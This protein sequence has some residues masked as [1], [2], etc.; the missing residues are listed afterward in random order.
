MIATASIVGLVR[1]VFIILGII[2]V[3]RFIGQF[4]M[5]KKRMEED[6]DYKKSKSTFEKERERHLKNKGKI[7]ISKKSKDDFHDEDFTDYEEIKE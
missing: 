6:R 4:F 3:L 1:M 7:T 5:A 2:L